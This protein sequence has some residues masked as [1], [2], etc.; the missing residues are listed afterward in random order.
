[1]SQVSCDKMYF[2]KCTHEL[3][4]LKWMEERYAVGPNHLK[5]WFP[6]N[7]AMRAYLVNWLVEVHVDLT[8]PQEA[9]FVTVNIIDRYL[10]YK[11]L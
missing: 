8:L 3:D 6:T 5:S 9:L 4:Y 11:Y 1:M 2:G 7:A 10:A